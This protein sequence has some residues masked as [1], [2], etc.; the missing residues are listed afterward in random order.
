MPAIL[1][2]FHKIRKHNRDKPD[3]PDR[4][5]ALLE[6]KYVTRLPYRITKDHYSQAPCKKSILQGLS[7]EILGEFS[8]NLVDMNSKT[9][10][11][12]FF[13]DQLHTVYPNNPTTLGQQGSSGIAWIYF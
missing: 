11:F 5:D 2:K 4:I 7:G 8:N 1:S 9:D 13:G 3:M 10:P 6:R 12:E